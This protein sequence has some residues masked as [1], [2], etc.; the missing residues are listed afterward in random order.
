MQL[1]LSL[2][3]N[4]GTSVILDL[5]RDSD[6]REVM[7]LLNLVI[8][9]GTSYPQEQPLELEGFH[10]YWRQAD[11]Y[12]LRSE[13][14]ALVGAFCLRPNHPG[15]CSHVANGG[16]LVEPQWRGRGLGR[17][18]GQAM[19]ALATEAGYEAIQ[20]NLVFEVNVASRRLAD[21]LGFRVIG[22]IPKA[23]RL[24][25]G[26]YTDALIYYRLLEH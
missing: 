25:S 2:R 9:E 6:D 3:L 17:Q 24:P 8:A 12:T 10:R 22:Q 5:H 16:F 13:A 26:Q 19:I 11:A 23:A 4:D 20:F 21:S 7:A 15:R 1:P 18:M 14:G